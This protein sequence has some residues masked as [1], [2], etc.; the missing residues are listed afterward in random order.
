MKD[1]MAFEAARKLALEKDR[2]LRNMREVGGTDVCVVEDRETGERRMV[3]NKWRIMYGLNVA[4][5][6]SKPNPAFEE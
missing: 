3:P 4:F 2:S 6:M 1:I 5:E